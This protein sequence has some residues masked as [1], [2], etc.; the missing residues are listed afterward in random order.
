MILEIYSAWWSKIISVFDPE[1]FVCLSSLS[2]FNKTFFP[3]VD[4][5]KMRL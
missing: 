2:E 1:K 3:F 4:L 5:M